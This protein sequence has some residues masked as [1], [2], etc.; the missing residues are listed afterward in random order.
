M[1]KQKIIAIAAIMGGALL[2]AGCA[3]QP[4]I[5]NQSTD[6]DLLGKVVTSTAEQTSTPGLNQSSK[7]VRDAEL[8]ELISITKPGERSDN[9]TKLQTKLKVLGFYPIAVTG[10]YGD[11]AQKGVAEYEEAIK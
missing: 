3:N 2:L 7:I 11:Y 10:Y 8:D 4:S 6:N 9:V 1:S 5:V